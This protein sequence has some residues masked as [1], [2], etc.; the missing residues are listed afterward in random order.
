MPIL[1]LN[2]SSCALKSISVGL[3][4]PDLGGD[5]ERLVEDARRVA[6]RNAGVLADV[7]EDR[8]PATA[9]GRGAIARWNCELSS[10]ST[11][12]FSASCWNK[13]LHLLQ[14]VRH[15]RREVVVLREILG[16][17]VQLPPVVAHVRELRVQLPRRAPA[18]ACWR[19]SPRCRCRGCR[20]SRSTASCASRARSHSPNRTCTPCSRL[21]SASGRCRP[22]AAAP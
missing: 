13:R 4:F 6:D 22:P 18:D 7:G 9:L 11:S 5:R 20:P 2:C 3:N 19:T 17:V 1:T 10:G 12:Y 16:E 8:L 15:L 14:L 21:R